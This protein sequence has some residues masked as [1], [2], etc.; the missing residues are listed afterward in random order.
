MKGLLRPSR[1]FEK[2]GKQHLFRRFATHAATLDVVMGMGGEWDK[3][4]SIRCRSAADAKRVSGIWSTWAL[5]AGYAEVALPAGVLGVI[6][7]LESPSGPG[8][9]RLDHREDVQLLETKTLGALEVGDRVIV[10]G[11]HR[12]PGL[13]ARYMFGSTLRARGIARFPETKWSAFKAKPEPGAAMKKSLERI[14]G[15]AIAGKTER[16]TAFQKD[17]RPGALIYTYE[18]GV[19]RFLRHGGTKRGGLY[20]LSEPVLTSNFRRTSGPP[21][22]CISS[23]C[24]PIPVR[25]AREISRRY[26]L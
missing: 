22:D 6:A 15:A 3:R 8:R 7:T 11:V 4:I 23:F 21:S 9:I 26:G 24:A 2:N 17:C 19:H 13:R 20:V 14:A 16:A 10:T 18:K 25:L 12:V 5:D 1:H